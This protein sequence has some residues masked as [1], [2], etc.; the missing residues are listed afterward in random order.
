MTSWRLNHVG[1]CS[2]VHPREQSGEQLTI[3]D[4][5][6]TRTVLDES[7]KQFNIELEPVDSAEVCI[8][9]FKC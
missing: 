6:E 9:G 1:D 5:K 8:I 7:Y 2:N 3:M 4:K